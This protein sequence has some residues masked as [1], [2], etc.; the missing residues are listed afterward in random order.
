MKPGRTLGLSLAIIAS[1]MLFTV[2]PFM[3]IA[4][5]LLLN[6]HL[7]NVDLNMP[8]NSGA[9]APIASGGNFMG[10]DNNAVLI[11]GVL[12]LIF[13]VIA[14]YA[15]RGRPS[16]IRFAT[17][18]AVVVL[19]I[20]TVVYSVIPLSHDPNLNEGIDSGQS[21]AQTLL[22][23]RLMLSVL[24]ALYVVWYMNRGPARAY[25]RG[26]YLTDPNDSA[27]TSQ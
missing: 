15:W 4:T 2:L 16:W 3:Q 13:L 23:G 26:Y 24:V 20:V 14:F 25:Y 10:V 7:R 21:L 11:Q 9:V 1:V 22:S 18:A 8:G 6:Y 17:L 27:S 5:L 19:T 12:G